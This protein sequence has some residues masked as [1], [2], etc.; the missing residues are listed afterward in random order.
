MSAYRNKGLEGSYQGPTGAS[1]K[2]HKSSTFINNKY[3]LV[4]LNVKNESP[5]TNETENKDPPQKL[6]A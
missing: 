2:L 3:L 5:I 4:I 1:K 6:L